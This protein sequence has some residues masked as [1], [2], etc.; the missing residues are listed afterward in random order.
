MAAG[1]LPANPGVAAD[2]RLLI[3]LS[4]PMLVFSWNE[5][6]VGH[7]AKHAVTPAE[8]EHVVR[9]ARPPFPMKVE[10]DKR[11]VW[12]PTEDGRPLQVVFVFPADEEIEP[13]ALRAA[14]LLAWAA[15]EADVVYVIHA[16][17]LTDVQK[18]QYRKARRKKG[19]S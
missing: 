9:R 17:E 14:D 10:D 7:I 19:Q 16:M 4:K 6:N 12:G 11:V 8:A 5:W 3:Y 2:R 13:D 18:R 15:G 1:E